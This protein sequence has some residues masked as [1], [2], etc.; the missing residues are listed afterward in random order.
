MGEGVEGVENLLTPN[1]GGTNYFH[2]Q[3]PIPNPQFLS[4]YSQFII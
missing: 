2:A 4:V 1:S 3:S